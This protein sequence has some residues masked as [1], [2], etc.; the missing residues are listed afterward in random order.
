MPPWIFRSI[1]AGMLCR[2][3]RS[4]D[5]LSTIWVYLKISLIHVKTVGIDYFGRDSLIISTHAKTSNTLLRGCA[6]RACA[7]RVWH[8]AP[9]ESGELAQASP[10]VAQGKN[11]RSEHSRL[12]VLPGGM[13]MH[14]PHACLHCY[15][16]LL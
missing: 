4:D 1:R 2:T 14:T 9:H 3:D 10:C 13:A 5:R 8:D 16:L 11:T 7:S 6:S 15:R 12:H